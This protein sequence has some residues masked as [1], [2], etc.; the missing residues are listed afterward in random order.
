VYRPEDVVDDLA[1][2]TTGMHPE[3]RQVRYIDYDRRLEFLFPV[4][5]EGFVDEP[6]MCGDDLDPVVRGEAGLPAPVVPAGMVAAVTLALG[7]RRRTA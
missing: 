4:C 5:G 7:L 6:G 3:N 2:Y 1:L